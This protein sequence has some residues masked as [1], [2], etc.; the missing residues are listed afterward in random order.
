M[1]VVY[2]GLTAGR[3]PPQ[4]K[5]VLGAIPAGPWVGGLA[6]PF[7]DVWI[8]CWLFFASRG[9]YCQPFAVAVWHAMF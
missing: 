4:W 9:P 3:Q 5:F 1:S 6:T 7:Q 8:C 2:T